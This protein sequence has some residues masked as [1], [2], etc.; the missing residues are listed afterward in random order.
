MA[1]DLKALGRFRTERRR[2]SH[3]GIE[4]LLADLGARLRDHF[5]I[6]PGEE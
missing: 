4:A 1:I 5:G 3:E 6:E 2:V